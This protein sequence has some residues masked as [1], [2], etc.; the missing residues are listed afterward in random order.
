VVDTTFSKRTVLLVLV[1]LVLISIALR[2]PLVAHERYQTDSYIVHLLSKSI[3]DN[4]RALWTFSPLSYFGYYPLSY[5]SG[6]PF[7]TAELSETTGMSIEFSI[8]VSNVVFGVLFTFAMF[9]LARQFIKKPEYILL[10]T[11]LVILGA[12][13]VDTTYWDGSARGP[14]VVMFILTIFTAFR[15]AMTSQRALFGLSMTFAATCFAIHHMAVLFVLVGIGFLL[16]SSQVRFILPVIQRQKRNVAVAFNLAVGVSVLVISFS[17][18]S[19]FERLA[20]TNLQKSSLFDLQPPVLSVIMNMI[21]SYTNQVGFILVF[22]LMGIVGLLRRTSLSIQVLFPIAVLITFSPLVGN[23][24]Y[25]SMLIA[26]FVGVLGTLYLSRL[27]RTRRRRLF[28]LLIVVLISV[29]FFIPVWSTAR[30]NSARYVGGYTVEVHDQIFNDAAYLKYNYRDEFAISNSEFI[31]LQL[32]AYSDSLF[33]DTGISLALNG[34]VTGQE[35]RNNV[36]WSPADF[37]SNFYRWFEYKNEP[38]VN[39]YVWGLILVGP[40]YLTHSAYYGDLWNYFS[41]HSRLVVVID[42]SWP[43]EYV[44]VYAVRYAAFPHMLENASWT[45]VENGVQT[46]FPIQSY[47]AY[48]SQGITIYLTEVPLS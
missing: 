20:Y 39:Y 14:M 45:K 29:S 11:L 7:L 10:A 22:A 37:P 3:A 34:D 8:L 4:G 40:V 27:S 23:T 31:K 2:Y 26:P 5:P 41:T 17:Y 25:T 1:V 42:N 16:A 15:A 13:F 21:A 24:L 33:L 38:K 35:V 36:T 6:I 9:V 30:W 32:A 44:D 19:V 28:T 48:R 43:D 18:F 46:S 47:L 12:R